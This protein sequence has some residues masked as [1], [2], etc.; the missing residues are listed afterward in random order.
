MSGNELDRYTGDNGFLCSEKQRLLLQLQSGTLDVVG[1]LAPS[2]MY[3]TRKDYPSQGRL[4]ACRRVGQVWHPA[5]WDT[6][7]Q[8]VAA[9]PLG[10]P[11]P[12]H[13]DGVVSHMG[14]L[15]FATIMTQ[16]KGDCGV[17]S[18]LVLCDHRR[19]PREILVLRRQLQ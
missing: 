1:E 6:C 12:L 10:E 9:K 3:A 8:F 15:G 4:V 16:A 5:S 7:S 2:V 13:G 19:G 18:L 11:L 14:R 17:E